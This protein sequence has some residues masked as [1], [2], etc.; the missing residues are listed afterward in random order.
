MDGSFKQARR[1]DAGTATS[2]TLNRLESVTGWWRLIRMKSLARIAA[3][4]SALALTSGA[5]L[6]GPAKSDQIPV[7][8]DKAGDTLAVLYSGDGGWAPLDQ[9]VARY[10]ADNGVPTV[11]VNS[12]T[13]F[14]HQALGGRRGRRSGRRPARVPGAVGSQERG[15]DR[16]LVRRRRP[17]GDHPA[18]ASRPSRPHQPPGADR[19]RSRKA[20][21]SSI[22][23]AGSTSPRRTRFQ[24]AQ[25]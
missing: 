1:P 7:T 4:L 19:N 2:L 8:S 13:L 6:P 15:A 18:T 3:V 20:I 9:K 12:L 23:P 14:P 11:G 21:C 25:R 10:L 17:A 5:P 16:L 24:C 22:R